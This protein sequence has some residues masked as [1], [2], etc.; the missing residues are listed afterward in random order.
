[1]SIISRVTGLFDLKKI[2]AMN[3]IRR[4]TGLFG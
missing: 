1:M 3:I 2:N 4:V